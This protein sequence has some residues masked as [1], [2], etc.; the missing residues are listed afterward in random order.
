MK[1]LRLRL[2]FILA[3]ALL[4][5]LVFSIWRS[6]AD[7][8]RDQA[9]LR[10]NTNLTA[11]IALSKIDNSF[12][13]TQSILRFTSTLLAGETC[14]A[15]LR[16]LT[17]E[18]PRFYN[19]ISADGT[20]KIN[21]SSKPVRS[22]SEKA[23]MLLDKLSQNAPF[24][25]AIFNLP[26]PNGE[27]ERVIATAHAMFE[28]GE[29]SGVLVAAEDMNFLLGL[30]QES[31]ILKDSEIA[32][33]N[34]RGERLGGEWQGEDLQFFA[35]SLPAKEFR[36]RLDLEDAVGRSILVL[37]TPADDIFLAISTNK[38]KS[39][40]WKNFNP[41]TYAAIPVLAWL[42]GFGAIWLATDQLIL[43]HLRRMR[44]ATLEFAKGNR[45]A[46]VGEMNNPPVSIYTLGKN[47]DMMADRIAER[48]ATIGDALDEKETLLR[49]IHHR[50]KNNLQIIISLL[51]MQ[52]RKLAD[53][54]GLAA[55][56]DTRSRINAISLVHRGLYESKDLRFVDMQTFL[57]R[58]LLE[59]A[60]AL[61]LKERDITVSTRAEC[62]PME[63]DIATPVA[64]FIVE[65]LTN[66]VKHG[67]SGGGQIKIDISQAATGVNVVVSD[68]G[69][70]PV[71]T[72][73]NSKGM[74][75]KLMKGFARQLG[76][77]LTQRSGK[78]GFEIALN[79]TLR[80]TD[81]PGCS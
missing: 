39:S 37:P 47:F 19:L 12:V 33:F 18:Y 65:A 52:E 27:P 54:E 3:L 42:F 29:I 75:M 51:N 4:P 66:A 72:K 21:C 36:E 32:I 43:I 16:R 79:F 44:R 13:K 17:D 69:A 60:V 8:S 50:V 57:D 49:E 14:R 28:N 9:L 53:E 6:Y 23:S 55:I 41:L 77:E 26:S 10:S 24:A 34:G 20:G 64:L 31:K 81:A 45:N 70:T 71:V 78:G 2:G 15:D 59:L 35:D 76:G 74:G 73:K 48:E 1:D 61:G 58:L 46:R 7:Y 30:L 38:A 63:A 11:R 40:S 25:T 80:G 62:D 22:N 56:V 67:M 5:L 68:T